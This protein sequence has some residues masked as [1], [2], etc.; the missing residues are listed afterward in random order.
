MLNVL[1][2]SSQNSATQLF[3][4]SLFYDGKTVQRSMDNDSGKPRQ[5]FSRIPLHPLGAIPPNNDA[6][7]EVNEGLLG[8][9]LVAHFFVYILLAVVYGLL[10]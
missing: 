1:L 5:L 7:P 6:S 3:Q 2:I 8:Q 9:S 10:F 4:F